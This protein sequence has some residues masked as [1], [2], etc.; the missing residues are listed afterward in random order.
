MKKIF[1]L[2]FILFSFSFAIGQSYTVESLNVENANLFNPATGENTKIEC[3][4][5]ITNN[6]DETI[7][8]KW[9]KEDIQMPAGWESN[10]C[11]INACY[12]P[13]VLTKSFELPAKASGDFYV[14]VTVTDN[15]NS[16]E[17]QV[18]YSLVGGNESY[19][20]IYKF[21]TVV[22]NEQI[23]QTLM[24]LYPNPA[25]DFFTVDHA[26]KVATIEVSN[27]LGEKVLT[28][29]NKQV[30]VSQLKAGMYFVRL[31]DKKGQ[32]IATKRLQKN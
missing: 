24:S 3:K 19:T 29:T 32:V 4:F 7:E 1:T 9:V 26:D 5:K 20:G 25:S 27:I 17:V 30:N 11:D 21:M 23:F 18:V 12:T 13:K 28:T 15:E 6:T 8:I 22:G 10:I 16:A 31:L 2:A 14:D